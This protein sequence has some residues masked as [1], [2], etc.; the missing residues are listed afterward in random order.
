MTYFRYT[1]QPREGMHSNQIILNPGLARFLITGVYDKYSDGTEIRSKK[2][3]G[4][5]MLK[6]CLLVT[7]SEGRKANI[8]DYLPETAPWKIAQLADSIRCPNLYNETGKLMFNELLNKEGDCSIKTF[9]P[10]EYS[11]EKKKT[12]IEKYIPYGSLSNV[13]MDEENKKLFNPTIKVDHP[14][15]LINLDD[16]V[17]F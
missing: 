2:R 4:V 5:K 15:G 7:D 12:I 17:P 11:N 16:D 6:L 10:N 1:Y 14:D 13:S 8:Y 3:K 9:Y